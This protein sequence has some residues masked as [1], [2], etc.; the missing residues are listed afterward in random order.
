[1]ELDLQECVWMLELMG[2]EASWICSSEALGLQANVLCQQYDRNGQPQ[3]VPGQHA[4]G[5][6]GCVRS[7]EWGCVA[8][9]ASHHGQQ[10]G[11]A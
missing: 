8:F 5:W 7:H 4:A 11:Q 9:I 6:K 1:M 10:V 2:G 3:T